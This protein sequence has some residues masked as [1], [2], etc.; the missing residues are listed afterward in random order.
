MKRS[1]GRLI[2]IL[3]RKNQIYLNAAMKPLNITTAE[4][5]ILMYLYRHNAV[6]QEEISTYL[7]VD[8]ALTARTV[9]SLIKKGLVTK[10]KDKRCNKISMT[11]KGLDM[12]EAMVEKFVGWNKIMLEGMD[13][14]KRN[15]LFELLEEM[16]EKTEQH[17][18]KGGN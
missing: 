15:L 16:V 13:E 14:S 1:V 17:D 10:E 6:T 5:P 11:Q 2:S 18:L 4:Q 12:R 9:Q 8:K 3:Y 7:Q